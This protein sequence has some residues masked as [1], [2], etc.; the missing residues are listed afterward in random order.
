MQGDELCLNLFEDLTFNV[1]PKLMDQIREEGN[2]EAVAKKLI[3]SQTANWTKYS[4][5]V[6]NKLKLADIINATP[7]T[8]GFK[9]NFAE[10]VPGQTLLGQNYPNPFNM[11]TEIRFYLTSNK[12][13]SLK[14]YNTLGQ[15]IRNLVDN[16]MKSSGWHSIHWNGLD[17]SGKT[18]SSGI[19][20]YRLFVD[21]EV[22]N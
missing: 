5:L 20:I 19:Y 12:R 10:P 13:V 7:D 2:K 6:L 4:L 17:N 8:S 21:N 11:T 16:Q 15:E 9:L 3:P 18:L 1:F 14:V 22:K